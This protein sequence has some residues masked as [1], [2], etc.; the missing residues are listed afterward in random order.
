[1][2]GFIDNCSCS[3]FRYCCENLE[4]GE[5]RN[6]I[7]SVVSGA[8]FAA[9]W[10]VIINAAIVYDPTQLPNYV[11]ACGSVAT[12]AFFMVNAVANGQIRGDLYT[13]GCLGTAGARVWLLFAF[14]LCF[15]ALIASMWILFGNYVVHA[16][17]DTMVG[18]GVAVFVQNFLIFLSTMCFKFGRSEELWD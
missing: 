15:G 2:S 10:W 14:L 17:A 11:H 9:G 12:V 18:A 7:A 5:K 8:L 13:D 1:M 16:S 4:I 6:T 3:C